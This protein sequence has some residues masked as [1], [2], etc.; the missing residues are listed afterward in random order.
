MS[1]TKNAQLTR[2]RSVVPMSNSDDTSQC[3]TCRG[4]GIMTIG[5]QFSCWCPSCK[6]RSVG[7]DTDNEEYHKP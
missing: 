2:A 7:E 4:T 6:N 3:N 1:L 5:G